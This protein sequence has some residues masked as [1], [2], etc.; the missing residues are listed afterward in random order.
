MAESWDNKDFKVWTFHLRKDAKWSNGEPVTAGLRIQLAASGG[1]ETASPYASY[2]QYGH[3]VNVDEIID[4]KK[5]PSELGVKPLTTTRWKSPSANRYPIFINC[6]LTRR[7]LPS[8]NRPS[9][10]WRKVDAAG[11]IVTNG[12]Y[13]LKDWVVNE[14]IVMERNPHYWDNAKTVINTVTAADLF[15]SDLC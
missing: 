2:P 10:I 14:R 9:K 8:T 7:C 3:I 5:A 1:S 6:W 11:N 13:T 4:G 15:R 12:A